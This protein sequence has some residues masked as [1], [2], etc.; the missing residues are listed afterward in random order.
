[1][2]YLF[3]PYSQTFLFSTQDT[4]SCPPLYQSRSAADSEA[5]CDLLH[6]IAISF[7][8]CLDMSLRKLPVINERV[9]LTAEHFQAST[10]HATA[11]Q[12]NAEMIGHLIVITKMNSEM[13]KANYPKLSSLHSI[14]I[15]LYGLGSVPLVY[16]T[17]MHMYL[18]RFL[19]DEFENL[20]YRNQ[21][22]TLKAFYDHLHDYHSNRAS[23]LDLSLLTLLAIRDDSF[24]EPRPTRPL[25]SL[26]LS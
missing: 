20:R 1:M 2:T 5:A 16:V 17:N 22:L 21:L 26:T 23:S 11:A 13:F 7:R 6:Y 12:E 10:E 8:P 18:D 9:R 19:S 14:L 3:C 24:S 4:L 15:E 25:P